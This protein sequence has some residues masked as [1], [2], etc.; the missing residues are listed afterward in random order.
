MQGL[1]WIYV[2]V[3]IPLVGISYA[4]RMILLSLFSAGVG[5]SLR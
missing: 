5:D 3:L 2:C 1:I 4:S